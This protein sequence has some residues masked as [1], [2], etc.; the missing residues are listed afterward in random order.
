MGGQAHDDSTFRQTGMEVSI[1][2]PPAAAA[3]LTAHQAAHNDH[4]VARSRA[5]RP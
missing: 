2:L 1:N 4:A 3:V 5:R